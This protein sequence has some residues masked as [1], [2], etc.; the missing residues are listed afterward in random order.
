MLFTDYYSES[1]TESESVGMGISAGVGLLADGELNTLI[2]ATS[3]PVLAF[4][5]RVVATVGVKIAWN[6]VTKNN[7][8]WCDLEAPQADQTGRM[9]SVTA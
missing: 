9:Q 7:Q 3:A 1:V 6:C 5:V 2:I 8:V 4:A